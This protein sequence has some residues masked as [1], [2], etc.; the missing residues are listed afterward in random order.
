VDWPWRWAHRLGGTG[1][2]TSE[3]CVAIARSTVRRDFGDQA[4]SPPPGVVS[5]ANTRYEECQ[6]DLHEGIEPCQ[7]LRLLAAHDE[8][9]LAT[10][11]AS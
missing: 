5:P 6:L 11:R 1:A 3:D 2:T 8:Q 7:F 4:T 9:V 10:H